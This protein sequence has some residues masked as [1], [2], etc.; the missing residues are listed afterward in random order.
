M[1]THVSPHT[2][3]QC[4]VQGERAEIRDPGCWLNSNSRCD[5]P[6]TGPGLGSE[7]EDNV[8]RVGGDLDSLALELWGYPQ[9]LLTVIG[10]QS[11]SARKSGP[12]V[13]RAARAVRKFIFISKQT[14]H[15]RIFASHLT[16][17]QH[18]SILHPRNSSSVF[19]HVYLE[20]NVD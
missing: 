17:H 4:H 16:F 1:M 19:T 13:R 3:G 20:L 9:G 18:I 8:H 2:D 5:S 10:Q 12:A 7:E 11:G 15:K 6:D 14:N